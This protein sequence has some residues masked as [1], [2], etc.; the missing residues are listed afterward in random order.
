MDYLMMRNIA[1]YF[2][3]SEI[4]YLALHENFRSVFS[5]VLRM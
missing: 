4:I 1:R 3:F 5:V 2:V